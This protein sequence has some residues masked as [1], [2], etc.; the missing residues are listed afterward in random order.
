MSKGIP[1]SPKH[2]V[3]PCMRVCFWCGEVDGIALMGRIQRKDPHTGRAIRGSDEEA[4]KQAVLDYDPCPKCRENWNIGIV[5]L[6]AVT[7]QPMDNR[8]PIQEGVYPTG[9]YVVIKEEAAERVFPEYPG[10]KKGSPILIEKPVF[11]HM[12]GSAEERPEG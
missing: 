9:R 11:E 4:P 8:P 10:L 5:C 3:N 7:E 12:F 1:L 6:E 2:G